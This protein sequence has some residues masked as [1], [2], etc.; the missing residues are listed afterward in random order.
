MFLRA[1]KSGNHTYLR[2]VESYRLHGQPRQRVVA[3]LGRKDLLAPHLDSLVRLL[4]ADQEAPRW[5]AS[6]QVA[7]PQ[8]WSWGPLHAARHLFDELALG[9]ILDE[10]SATRSHGQPLSE[11]VFVLLAN[12]LTRPGS[13]HALAEWLEDFYVVTAGGS[14]WQPQWKQRRRVKV[15]FEQL[16]LWYQTLD[17]LLAHKTH[18]ETAIWR[19][20]RDLFSLAP[21]LVFYDLTSTYFEGQGPAELGRFG[22]SRNS[23]PRKRQVLVGVVMRQGWPIAHHVFAGNRPDQAT[24]LEVVADLGSRFGLQRVVWVGTAAW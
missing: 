14:R 11:R 1:H 13:E 15:A 9:P 8:A 24:L 23:P 12:R 20:L 6:E 19:Q 10:L 7:A 2:L 4:Q 18:I 16:R 22:Y 5:V 17:D 21:E 3:H